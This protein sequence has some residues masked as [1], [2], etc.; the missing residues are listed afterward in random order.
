MDGKNVYFD[1][2]DY[3]MSITVN[4]Q[5]TNSTP[6]K[7]TSSPHERPR[8]CHKERA[9]DAQNTQI[10]KMLTILATTNLHRRRGGRVA[11]LD[12]ATARKIRFDNEPPHRSFPNNLRRHRAFFLRP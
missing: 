2:W 6:P 3:N 12:P 5:L 8:P 9:R 1:G 10:Q 4:S 7:P 11:K